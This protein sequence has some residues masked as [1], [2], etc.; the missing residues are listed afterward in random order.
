MAASAVTKSSENV[1]QTTSHE[2]P[3]D[4]AKVCH[5]TAFIEFLM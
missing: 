5:T 2:L 4:F 1:K 3:M